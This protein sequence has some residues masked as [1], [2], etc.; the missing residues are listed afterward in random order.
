[1]RHEGPV[2]GALLTKNEDRILSWSE[3]KPLRLWD[4]R[5]PQGNL[6]GLTCALLLDRDLESLSKRYGIS[7]AQPICSPDQIT[8]AVDWS[9]IE[10]APQES[11]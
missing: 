1:M 11:R 10:R 3:D 8:L 9:K 4:M 5:W 7:I 6:L 2:S